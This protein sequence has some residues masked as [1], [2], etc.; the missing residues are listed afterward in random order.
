MKMQLISFFLSE[1]F[2]YENN[3]II[4]SVHT[5]FKQT[6]SNLRRNYISCEFWSI[7]AN[8]QYIRKQR[9]YTI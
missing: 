2:R 5:D 6:V 8:E 7:A 4:E 9:K 3:T 1:I